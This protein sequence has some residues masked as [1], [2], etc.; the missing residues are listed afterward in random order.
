MPSLCQGG[1]GHCVVFL[2]KTLYSHSASLHTGVPRYNVNG[3]WSITKYGSVF[4]QAAQG[5]VDGKFETAR[6]VGG[7]GGGA[8]V[9]LAFPPGGGGIILVISC[10]GNLSSGG[11]GHFDPRADIAFYNI[12]LPQ[13]VE[14]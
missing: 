5:V 8:G 7:G 4:C 3:K 10:Y 6:L 9:G 11:V 13:P 14:N 12:T 1:R 2:G